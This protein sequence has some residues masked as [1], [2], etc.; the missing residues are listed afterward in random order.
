MFTG[1]IEEIGTIKSINSNGISSQLCINANKILED[2]KIGDSIAVNGVCLTVTSIK[3]N[4]FTADVMAETLRR[5]NLGSL[6]PQSKVN[7]ERAMPAN[8]RFGGHIVSGHIDG[9]GTIVETKPEGNAVWI[10]INCS[11]NLLKY[12]IHKGSITIDGISLTVAKVTDSDFSVSI[13]P[14]TA[15]NT[16]L[17]QKKSGDVV[18]LENDVVGKYI[19]KLLSFQ[20]IDEQKPQS[21]ITEEFLRQNG[22]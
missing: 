13:I 3:S 14:H 9:T 21:K 12:I 11:D 18:N 16:T 17:L 10:K 8:G 1:I 22:F 2:T 4:L 7:L 6:I 20:K 19:E 15:A 5:S